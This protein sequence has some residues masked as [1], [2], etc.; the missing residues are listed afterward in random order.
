MI[1]NFSY[2]ILFFGCILLGKAIGDIIV[3]LFFM[4]KNK[5]R[6]QKHNRNNIIKRFNIGGTLYNS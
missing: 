5:R 6:N 4:V 2:L 3:L 1:L